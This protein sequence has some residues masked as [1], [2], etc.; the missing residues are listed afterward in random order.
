[1]VLKLA[2]CVRVTV[3]VNAVLSEFLERGAGVAY[4]KAR[5]TY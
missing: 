4:L 5:E 3:S 1:M 2:S